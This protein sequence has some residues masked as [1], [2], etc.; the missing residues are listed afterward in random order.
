[1]AGV[2]VVAGVIGWISVLIQTGQIDS[3]PTREDLASAKDEHAQ[4]R[5]DLMVAQIER[6]QLQFQVD[7]TK[8]LEELKAAL[9]TGKAEL[10]TLQSQIEGSQA[11]LEQLESNVQTQ[12]ALLGDS[13]LQFKT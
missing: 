11:E 13:T 7:A 2:V 10:L 1:M 4:L 3:L 9:A 5:R 6:D 12:Q 8:S